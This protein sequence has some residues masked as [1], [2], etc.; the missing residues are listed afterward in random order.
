MVS[1]DTHTSSSTAPVSVKL[2]AN[3]EE[4]EFQLFGQTSLGFYVGRGQAAPA[5]D[6]PQ[7]S[8]AAEPSDD[9]PR[10]SF[11]ASSSHTSAMT[12]PMLTAR[13]VDYVQ[14]F[15]CTSCSTPHRVKYT[16]GDLSIIRSMGGALVQC[17]NSHCREGNEVRTPLFHSKDILAGVRSLSS[18]SAQAAGRYPVLMPTPQSQRY[19]SADPYAGQTPQAV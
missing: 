5:D 14:S 10:A 9:I 18:A 11:A 17:L 7:A 8:F 4:Y 3:D 2:E 19:V 15:P 1:E 6:T 12:Q 13:S 16:A